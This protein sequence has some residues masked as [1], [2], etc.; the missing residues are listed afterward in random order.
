VSR[1]VGID[2]EG[3]VQGAVL[4]DSGREA[5]PLRRIIAGGRPMDRE[6][7]LDPSVTLRQLC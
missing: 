2:A 6:R 7:L 5:T 1:R 3:R 4:I